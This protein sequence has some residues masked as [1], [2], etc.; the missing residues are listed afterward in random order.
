VDPTASRR[1]DGNVQ[2]VLP[3]GSPSLMPMEWVRAG[4]EPSAA[5]AT[6][7]SRRFTAAGL[8]RLLQLVDAMSSNA[9]EQH[10]KP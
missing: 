2:V 10:S 3:D 7:S 9:G 1:H 5:T 6:N 8:R 4:A